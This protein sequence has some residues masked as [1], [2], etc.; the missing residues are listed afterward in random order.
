MTFRSLVSLALFAWAGV[1]PI[2]ADAEVSAWFAP[3]AGKVLHDARPNP[4][5]RTWDLAAARN[6]TEACQLVLVSDRPV[7]G[8][9]VSVSRFRH[10]DGAAEL[11]PALFKVEYVPNIVG[12]TP[13]PDPLPPLKSLDLQPQRAQPVW[14]SVKVPKDGAPGDYT[15]NVLLEVGEVRV[16]EYPLRLHVWN[17]ALPD[18]PSSATAFGLGREHIAQQHGV[19]VDSPEAAKLYARYYEML[20]DHRISAYTIPADLMSDAAAKYLDDPRMTSYQIPYPAEDAA[21]KALVARL[22]ER[23]WYGKGFF[24]PIDEPEDKPSYDALSRISDRLRECVPGHRWIVPFCSNAGWDD[25]LTPFDLM[26]NR[27]NLW[28]PNSRY[29]DKQPATRPT[30]AARRRLGEKIWWYVCCVPGEPYNNFFVDMTAMSHRVLLWQQK[31]ED[32]E[33]LLYWNTTYWDSACTQDPWTDMGT[34]RNIKVKDA[35]LLRGDGSLFYPGKQAGF[36]G[37]VS[38]LRLE[39]IRDGLEDFD[40]LTLAD[41]RLGKEATRGFILEIARSLTDYERDPLVLEKPRRKIGD[42]LER[43]PQP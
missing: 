38:S 13:Y 42:L 33:G 43:A 12:D 15:A 24:Y 41:A 35:A 22:V 32:V 8:A 18:T 11:H 7:S 10:V 27:V 19:S 3:S 17:F 1:L 5:A 4:N 2:P 37:P 23:G 21:L 25:Q 29:F 31:R 14:I 30:L 16:A 6:E 28:C 39:V 34:V 36:D 20:L 26:T 40:Y 9:T